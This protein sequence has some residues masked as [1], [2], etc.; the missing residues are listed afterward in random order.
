MK[1]KIQFLT[2]KLI[3]DI[4]LSHFKCNISTLPLNEF[5]FTFVLK[6]FLLKLLLFV[7]GTD[8]ATN[9][10]KL[11]ERESGFTF[12]CVSSDYVCVEWCVCVRER[13]QES[14]RESE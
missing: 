12:V 6:Y 8:I 1:S 2:N 5:S 3:T 7:S 14:E 11:N 4:I 13:E 9:R 10:T